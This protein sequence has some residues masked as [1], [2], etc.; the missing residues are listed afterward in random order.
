MIILT[1]PTSAKPLIIRRTVSLPVSL[2]SP[3]W[4]RKTVLVIGFGN[5]P[6]RAKTTCSE[7]PRSCLL[8]A[9][10]FLSDTIAGTS[11]PLPFNVYI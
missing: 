2:L 1:L 5:V 4:S 7:G 3:K 9:V 6:I 8:G 10:S 11:F